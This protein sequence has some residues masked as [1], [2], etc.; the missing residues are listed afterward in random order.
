MQSI[1]IVLFTLRL[2]PLQRSKGVAHHLPGAIGLDVRDRE[3]SLSGRRLRPV[4]ARYTAVGFELRF[5][6]KGKGATRT[7]AKYT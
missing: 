2:Y 4:I 1:S 6:P 3:L 5:C 7:R